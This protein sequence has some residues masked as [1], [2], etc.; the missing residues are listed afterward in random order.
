MLLGCLGFLGSGLFVGGT[1][2]VMGRGA[3]LV[4]V[5]WAAASHH[6]KIDALDFGADRPNLSAAYGAVVDL[7][8]RRNLRAGAT[9][10]DL[11]GAV[12]FGAVNAALAGDAAK[13]A[14]GQLHHRVAGHA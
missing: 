3:P 9:E 11:F 8:D 13:L 14:L 7:G 1:C 6:I 4:S 2:L 10:K 12:E 5:F